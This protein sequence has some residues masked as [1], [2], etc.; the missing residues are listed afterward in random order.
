MHQNIFIQKYNKLKL[1]NI[2]KNFNFYRNYHVTSAK[3]FD[4]KW[5]FKMQSFQINI[6][7]K[8]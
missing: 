7:L 5:Y 6:V 2:Q 1:G 8:V 3:K 4:Y